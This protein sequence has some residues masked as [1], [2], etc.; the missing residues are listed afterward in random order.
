MGSFYGPGA[1]PWRLGYNANW[2]MNLQSK[3]RT[4]DGESAVHRFS[5]SIPFR[6]R[7]Q[8]ENIVV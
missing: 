8:W 2:H 1:S 4:I 3:L 6:I 7:D 5:L